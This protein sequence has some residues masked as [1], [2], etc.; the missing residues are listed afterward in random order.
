MKLA[1]DARA[2]GRPLD[3]MDRVLRVLVGAAQHQEWDIELF[4]DDDLRTDSERFRQWTRPA[5]AAADSTAVA[6]WSPDT[7]VLQCNLPVVATLHDINPLLP[8]GRGRLARYLREYRF[9]HRVHRCLGRIARL[10]TDTDDARQRVAKV[11]PDTTGKLSVV[12]LFVDPEIN[13]LQ[14]EPRD[15]ILNG[16]GLIP[17]FILFVGSLRR[18]KNWEGLIRAFAAMPASLR[19]SHP[20]VFAGRAERSRREAEH[21][22]DTLGVRKDMRVLGVVD[23]RSLCAL[24]GGASVLAC[25]SFM[26]GFGFT[27][28][29]AMAC[30]L[31]VVAT[32]RT[33]VPEVLGDAPLYVDPASI[34]S[35]SDALILVLSDRAK[36]DSLIDAGLRR[37]ALFNPARTG[38]AMAQVLAML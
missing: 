35:I 18:H 17:G 9:R 21:L 23:E 5:T 7:N 29:E 33:C 8:D 28:L 19:V 22:A 26:E 20:L 27:P 13:A 6:L 38:Q 15:L 10:V 1:F 2:F 25:P 30:G 3:S 34:E 12:P 24:Y 37:A 16:L 14:G 32:N 36:R 31:P 4:I 11:F